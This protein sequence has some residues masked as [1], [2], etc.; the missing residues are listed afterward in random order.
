ML[1]DIPKDLRAALDDLYAAANVE[2]DAILVI[3]CSTSEVIGSKIGTAGNDDAAKAIFDTASAFC[4]EKKLFLAAQCCEHLN[5]SLVIEKSAM[6]KFALARVNAIPRREAG[7]AFAA[8]AYAGMQDPVLVES[9]AADLG[10]DIGGTLIGMHLR[11]VAVPVRAGVRKIGE[12]SL[13]LAR[14]RCRYVGGER[15]RY[16]PE[17]G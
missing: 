12:A 16:N 3:G 1:D 11:P 15:A 8:A 17:L 6:K 14:S 4:R 10:A 7:G 5:R 9:I 13:I 2:E